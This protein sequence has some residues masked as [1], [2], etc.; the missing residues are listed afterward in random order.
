[1]KTQTIVFDVDGVLADFMTGFLQVASGLFERPLAESGEQRAW[2][3][4]PGMAAD[5]VTTTWAFIAHHPQFWEHLPATASVEEFTA[6]RK[7]IL[8]GHR[9]YFAT[10]RKTHGALQ[11][12]HLWLFKHIVLP[13]PPDDFI[14]LNV[15][16]THRKGEF[17]KVVEADYYIDDKSENVDC[18][19]WMTDKKTKSYVIT[20][21]YNSGQFAPHSAKA[22]RVENVA[23]FIAAVKGN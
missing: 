22:L 15:I 12:T 20:R 13:A 6:I 16:T 14:P 2:D 3:V 21:P 9:V 11:A 7:L 17:C 5:E 4:Y 10:N 1:M 18:A 8:D 19:I 23:Q